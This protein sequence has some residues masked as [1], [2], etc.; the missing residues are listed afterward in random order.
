MDDSYCFHVYSM[1]IITAVVLEWIP[2]KPWLL[3]EVS[4]LS[5]T[6]IQWEHK[7]TCMGVKAVKAKGIYFVFGQRY[8]YSARTQFLPLWCPFVVH[9][10]SQCVKC[11]YP[12]LLW[13][14]LKFIKKPTRI[15]H[16]FERLC[17]I[18]TATKMTFGCFT[19]FACWGVTVDHLYVIVYHFMNLI[20]LSV[21]F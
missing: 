11:S 12:P 4:W 10:H 21:C 2:H 7:H 14:H 8:I 20:R 16:H 15:L 9:T 18:I 3:N 1:C 6:R 17:L 13:V 5:L 19:Q